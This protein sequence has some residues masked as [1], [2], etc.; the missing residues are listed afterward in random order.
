MI[1]SNVQLFV[2]NIAFVLSSGMLKG[3]SASQNQIRL[4][5]SPWMMR[6]SSD[7][8]TRS[9]AFIRSEVLHI[10]VC[11]FKA[12]MIFYAIPCIFSTFISQL[13]EIES[14]AFL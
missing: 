5:E 3:F 2:Y 9:P 8:S 11:H 12:T 6:I 13:C 10:F 7:I 4:S 1:S 14:K